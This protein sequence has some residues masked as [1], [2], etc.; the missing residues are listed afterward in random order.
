[1]NADHEIALHIKIHSIY[2][3]STRYRDSYCEVVG[4]LVYACVFA[5][6]RT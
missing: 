5:R 2:Q 3:E 6:E 4:S 1:M